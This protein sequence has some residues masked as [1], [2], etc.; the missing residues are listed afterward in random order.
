MVIMAQGLHACLVLLIVRYVQ[1]QRTVHYA[2]MGSILIISY[3][4][5]VLQT[6]FFAQ[7][8]HYVHYVHL[9]IIYHYLTLAYPAH[10]IVLFAILTPSVLS[11]QMDST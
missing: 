8:C 5:S 4:F 10:S 9:A 3:A 6:V 11:V 7:A 1:A 2:L